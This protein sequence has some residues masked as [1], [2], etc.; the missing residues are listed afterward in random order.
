M[1]R[2]FLAL[3]AAILVMHTNTSLAVE[4]PTA[5]PN[6]KEME[7][8]GLPRLTAEELKAYFPG[9]IDSKGPKGRH[10]IISNPDGTCLRKPFKH[11]LKEDLGRWR[12]DEKN[13]THC[14][15]MPKQMRNVMGKGGYE[16]NCFA[17]FRDPDGI[18]FFDYD[19]QDGFFAHVWRRS[20]DQ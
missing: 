14:R 9:V 4:F 12:I 13:N 19:V 2:Y 11:G 15:S 18:H 16:E 8:K 3:L 20:S 6:L 1:T 10:I 7:A 17:V 5:P